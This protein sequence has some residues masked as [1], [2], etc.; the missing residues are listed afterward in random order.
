M[1]ELCTM[2]APPSI[3]QVLDDIEVKQLPQREKKKRR[4][5]RKRVFPSLSRDSNHGRRRAKRVLPSS[6]SSSPS[7]SKAFCSDGSIANDP[8]CAAKLERRKKRFAKYKEMKLAPKEKD[9]VE[10]N[11]GNRG[12]LK[13]SNPMDIKNRRAFKRFRFQREPTL[14]SD[15]KTCS[16]NSAGGTGGPVKPF[17]FQRDCQNDQSSHTAPKTKKRKIVRIERSSPPEIV[18]SPKTSRKIGV[19]NFTVKSKK[20]SSELKPSPNKK[21]LLSRK[22]RQILK[23]DRSFRG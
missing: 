5:R 11:G 13:A 17:K 8:E 15:S 2:L 1:P 9:K 22:R 7:S 14:A 3:Q 20:D 23:I 19:M 16:L 10:R 12:K 21:P 4:E 6:Y 18:P